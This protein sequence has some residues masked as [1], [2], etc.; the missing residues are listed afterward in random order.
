MSN[1]E[2]Q[3]RTSRLAIASLV[4]PIASLVVPVVSCTLVGYVY[5]LLLLIL[6]IVCGHKARAQCLK[7]ASLTGGGIAL[8]GLIC[9]YI[10]IVVNLAVAAI[11]IWVY[12]ELYD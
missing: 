7:D 9:G 3:P 6:G 5:C 12:S 11:S 2:A 4:L 1:A 10:L 8:A